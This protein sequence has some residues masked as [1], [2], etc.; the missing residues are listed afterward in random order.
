MNISEVFLYIFTS[1]SQIVICNNYKKS[2][3]KNWIALL[4]KIT[5]QTI[6]E[7][8]TLTNEQLH[9]KPNPHTWSIAENL[10]HLIVLNESYYP[11]LE[12]LKAGSY[13]TPFI[14]KINFI[15]SFLGN[16]ILKSVQPDRR[17][18]MKT[19]QMWEPSKSNEINDIINRF[20]IHQHEL[21]LKIEEASVYIEKG[22]IISSPANKNIVYSL[23]TAFDII[24][25][26]EQR[27]LEQSKELLKLLKANI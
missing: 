6:T 27:H 11:I 25:S 21:I 9:W 10:D 12:S 17:K 22:C 1:F 14:A 8:G 26:H 13:Q 5:D 16:T 4:H 2:N 20:N 7:F 24:V 15:V 3:M 18:K 19:F 23:E